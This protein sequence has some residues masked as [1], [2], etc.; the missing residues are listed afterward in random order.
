MFPKLHGSFKYDYE[1]PG[2]IDKDFIEIIQECGEIIYV[3]S[4][5]H[6]VVW[7]L[8]DTISINHNWFNGT[9]ICFIW[10]SLVNAL[11]EVEQEICELNLESAVFI[12]TCQKI[13][14]A[15]HGMDYVSFVNVLKTI[16]KHRSNDVESR[17]LCQNHIEFDKKCIKHV[18]QAHI[19]RENSVKDLT[20]QNESFKIELQELKNALDCI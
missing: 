5:W 12:N 10:R 9:N 11:H 6:H 8:E 4:G 2:E 19:V 14:L 15:N 20:E 1:N 17:S 7:N 13:L 16:F 3:P 18:F